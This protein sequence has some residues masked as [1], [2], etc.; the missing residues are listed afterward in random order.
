MINKP[1]PAQDKKSPAAKY[2]EEKAGFANYYFN[3]LER[4]RVVAQLRKLGDFTPLTETWSFDAERIRPV[5]DAVKAEI[6]DKTVK[7]WDADE[8][9]LLR[10]LEG[11]PAGVLG[12]A[13]SSDGTMLASLSRDGT[14]KTWQVH[15]GK[16]LLNIATGAASSGPAVAFHPLGQ[17]LATGNDDGE[18]QLWDVSTGKALGRF[19]AHSWRVGES[20]RSRPRP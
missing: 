19:Q 3:K 5:K 13:F 10:T 6:G 14:V 18:I 15:T 17:V 9:K 2:Y 8:R 7:I 16:Q 20:W 1:N 11:H 12:L 4:D